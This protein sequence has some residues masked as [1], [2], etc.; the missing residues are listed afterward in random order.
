MN[1]SISNRYRLSVPD[2]DTSTNDWVAKQ[3]NLS[4]S[5]RLLVTEDIERN[6]YEDVT[7]RRKKKLSKTTTSPS[8]NVKDSQ[9]K[10]E[11]SKMTTAPDKN[12]KDNQVKTELSDVISLQELKQFKK[13]ITKIEKRIHAKLN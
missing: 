7:C 3:I 10:T 1:R 11:L 4:A 9:I 6:G 2:V 5:F 13:Y 8:K 12:T